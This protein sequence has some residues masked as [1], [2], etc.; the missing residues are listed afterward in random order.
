VRNPSVRHL[1][2]IADALKVSLAT[3]FEGL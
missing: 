1:V 3:L 2:R